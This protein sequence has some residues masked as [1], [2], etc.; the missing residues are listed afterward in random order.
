MVKHLESQSKCTLNQ[1]YDHKSSEDMLMEE[2]LAMFLIA[3]GHVLTNR[4]IQERF[5]HIG[6]TISKWFSLVLDIV[7]HLVVNTI[8]LSD[9]QFRA[10]QSK[11]RSDDRYWPYFKN[12]IRS[13][14]RT[15]ISL[16]APKDK[17]IS[18]I[19]RKGINRVSPCRVPTRL[20]QRI[21]I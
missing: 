12:Y 9:L 11:I 15:H 2:V 14:D 17:Q 1:N 3:L 5:Q 21:P 10:T 7:F 20:G 19:G 18:Y 13:I 16:V 6:E 8:K 4:M